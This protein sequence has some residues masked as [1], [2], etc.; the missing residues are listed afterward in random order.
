[1]KKRSVTGC[2][3]RSTEAAD[4]NQRRPRPAD[5][6]GDHKFVLEPELEQILQEVSGAPALRR[7]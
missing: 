6:D 5:G 4:E 3:T 7:E 2:A 1:M